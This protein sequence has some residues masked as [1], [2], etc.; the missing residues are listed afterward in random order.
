M[1]VIFRVFTGSCTL[2]LHQA[3]GAT[4][5]VVVSSAIDRGFLAITG[6][7]GNHRGPKGEQL[8]LYTPLGAN[9]GLTT[10]PQIPRVYQS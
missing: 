6:Y 5:L 1:R 9:P 2:P 10:R 3:D 7:F 4:I 8:E